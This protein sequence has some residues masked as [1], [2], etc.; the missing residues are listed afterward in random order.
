MIFIGPFD[1]HISLGLTPTLWSDTPEF[2]NAVNKVKSACQ[3][4]NIPLGTLTIANIDVA[5]QRQQEG[6]QFISVGT[7]IMHLVGSV[8]GQIKSLKH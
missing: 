6:F 2:V 3:R 8:T 5:R 1:L 4:A 7:D